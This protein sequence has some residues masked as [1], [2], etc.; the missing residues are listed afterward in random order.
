MILPMVKY[1]ESHGVEFR[2][3]TKVENVEFAIGRG[4]AGP[5]R[6]HTGVRPKTP[7]EDSG[8]LRLL[9][10]QPC[11]HAHQEACRAHRRGPRG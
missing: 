4:E 9:Q 10:A 5:K 11:Q 1:L 6:E 8:H 2:Y 3:N 7:P